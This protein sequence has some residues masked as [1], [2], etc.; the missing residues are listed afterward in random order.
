VAYTPLFDEPLRGNVYLRSSS[1]KLPDLVASLHSGA[2]HIVL[3]GEIG[4]TKQGGIQALFAELPDEPLDRFTMTLNGG[5]H[6]LL[7]NSYDICTEPPLATVKALGQNNLG[8]E[9][10]TKLRGQCKGKPKHTHKPGKHEQGRR[11]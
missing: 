7:Q 9:F 1:H 11:G 8:A 2:I 4:P 3:E 5:R 10:T 6:G